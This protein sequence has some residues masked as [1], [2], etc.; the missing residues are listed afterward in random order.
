ME[1]IQKRI[2]DAIYRLSKDKDAESLKVVTMLFD[3]NRSYSIDIN[4]RKSSW[5]ES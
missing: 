5:E 3:G 4:I 1:D 2:E